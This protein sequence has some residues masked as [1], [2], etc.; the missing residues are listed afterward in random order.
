MQAL[1]ASPVMCQTNLLTSTRIYSFFPNM[2][3]SVA[4]I[5]TDIAG[6]RAVR[7]PG[8]PYV[9]RSN[10]RQWTRACGVLCPSKERCTVGDKGVASFLWNVKI[11]SPSSRFDDVDYL[12][13]EHALVWRFSMKCR[14]VKCRNYEPSRRQLAS[15][16]AWTGGS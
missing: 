6:V 9:F 1:L 7:R 13:A 4:T 11:A 2:I 5:K 12:L 15:G 16:P 14:N 10:N 8:A 3:T